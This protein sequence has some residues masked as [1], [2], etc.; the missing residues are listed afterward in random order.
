VPDDSCWWNLLNSFIGC[1]LC[2][3]ITFQRR[4]KHL[5]FPNLI[6]VFVVFMSRN[7]TDM[8]DVM[9]ESMW[10]VRCSSISGRQFNCKRICAV[11]WQC[12]GTRCHEFVDINSPSQITYIGIVWGCHMMAAAMQ[13]MILNTAYLHV[14][15][16]LTES[17]T[18]PAFLTVRCIS[19]PSGSLNNT[20][21][22]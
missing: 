15:A 22:Q 7:A 8:L 19:F 21:L 14:L 11:R 4:F 5:Y 3:Y 16:C 2:I 17:P 18:V 10:L 6:F 20:S 12:R 13:F 1:Q 9:A